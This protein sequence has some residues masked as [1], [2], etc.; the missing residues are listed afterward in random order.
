M[1]S[2]SENSLRASITKAALVL[3]LFSAAPAFAVLTVTP[4]DQNGNN[5]NNSANNTFYYPVSGAT[6]PLALTIP[7]VA[8]NYPPEIDISSSQAAP[9]PAGIQVSGSPLTSNLLFFTI[10]ADS[11]SAP[12]PNSSVSASNYVMV[13]SG[14]TAEPVPIAYFGTA[15][16]GGTAALNAC[17][18]GSSVG[19]NGC[20]L[21]SGNFAYAVP[22]PTSGT[23]LVIGIS[24]ADLCT[25]LGGDAATTFCSSNAVINPTASSTSTVSL[26]FWIAAIPSSFT[27]FAPNSFP[28][29]TNSS[30]N[31]TFTGP[32]TETLD[33]Q[34]A[35]PTS[36]ITCPDIADANYEQNFYFPGDQEIFLNTTNFAYNP[37]STMVGA[38]PST[39]LLVFAEAPASTSGSGQV[40]SLASSSIFQT[41]PLNV[42]AGSPGGV[43]VNGLQDSTSGASYFYNFGFGIIDQAGFIVVDSTQSATQCQLNNVQVTSVSG[44]LGSSKCFIAT[45]AYRSATAAPVVML[46]RF[47]DQVLLKFGPGRRFVDWYY[48]WSPGAAEWL[49]AHPVYRY[50]VLVALVPVEIFAWLC[51]NPLVFLMLAVGI[52]GFSVWLKYKEAVREEQAFEARVRGE[53]P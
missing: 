10:N 31:V 2:K 27:G 30:T 47:R 35:P 15:A 36:N 6:G 37:S 16:P 22:Y 24:P 53:W 8:S 39:G 50:P 32:T 9:S 29:T 5:Y 25:S 43:P 23:N 21:A 48:S 17:V 34:S 52:L 41:V 51:L 12:T 14:T 40:P 1:Q 45:A 19:V 4:T 26:S 7:Q 18:S 44:F 42:G 20:F 33:L 11:S 49:L 3:A 38:A 13:F 28:A 46:R